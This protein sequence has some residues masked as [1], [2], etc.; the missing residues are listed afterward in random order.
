MA[1]HF[2]HL[3]DLLLHDS[4]RLVEPGRIGTHP[5][6]F[7]GCNPLARV[8][9]WLAQRF[10]MPR[11]HQERQ[12]IIWPAENPCRLLHAQARRPRLS[13][14]GCV[15]FHW[16]VSTQVPVLLRF[17]PTVA[18]YCCNANRM[19]SSNA[20]AAA[21]SFRSSP[22][23]ASSHNIFSSLVYITGS[24]RTQTLPLPVSNLPANTDSNFAPASVPS[25]SFSPP[26]PIG[27]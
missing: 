6:D 17:A 20:R 14:D 16:S 8:L 4:N 15:S 18:S 24:G 25:A 19:R 11:P 3:L 27:S 22:D 13:V 7:N 23:L 9:R 12:V 21:E 1:S 26:S 10:E 2:V 5:L